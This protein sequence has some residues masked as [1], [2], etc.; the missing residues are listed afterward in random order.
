MACCLDV[1]LISGQCKVP[2]STVRQVITFPSSHTL[3]LSAV[4]LV[5]ESVAM[6]NM[7]RYLELM[8]DRKRGVQN[9]Q[10]LLWKRKLSAVLNC[11]GMSVMTGADRYHSVSA[12]DT[13][14]LL[15]LGWENI[16]S[17]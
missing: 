14:L 17:K 8:P 13:S 15:A 2:S 1:F 3:D 6:A 9:S 5:K 11:I 12:P 10:L 7:D 16:T 4:L